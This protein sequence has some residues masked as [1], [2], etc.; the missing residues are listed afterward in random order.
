MKPAPR[1]LYEEYSS[2]FSNF[3]EHCPELQYSIYEDLYKKRL[4]K[5]TGM[6]ILDLGCGKGEWLQW[7]KAKGFT[8]LYGV[9]CSN[10][11]QKGSADGVRLI[12]ADAMTFLKDSQDRFDLIHAKDLIEHLDIEQALEFCR[13]IRSRLKPGGKI[14]LVTYNA[15]APFSGATRYSDLTHRIGLTPM[16]ACQLLSACGYQQVECAGIHACP[17]TFKGRL[18]KILNRGVAAISRFLL[19]LRH[20]SKGAFS[21]CNPDIFI[22]GVNPSGAPPSEVVD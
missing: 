19:D 11:I 8:A 7:L 9:D 2:H 12:Q 3:K 6:T 21:D 17:N 5:D 16:S 1:L 10:D 15:Q 20:G 13:L 14:W 4:P 18:R 22:R